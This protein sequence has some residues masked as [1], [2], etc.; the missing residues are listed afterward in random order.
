MPQGQC[1]EKLAWGAAADGGVVLEFQA[2][3][4]DF[5]IAAGSQRYDLL[6][7]RRWHQEPGGV[8]RRIDVDDFGVGPEEFFKGGKVVSPVAFKSSAPLA[9]L[10]ASAASDLEAALV[11]RCFDDDVI[12]GPH[13]RVIQHENGFF[14]GG[15]YKNV[16]GLDL[17]VDVGDG[18]AQ[19]GSAG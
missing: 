17:F 1:G 18:F 5:W 19:P 11:T 12:A 8:V 7:D 13:Q 16:A 3:L 9:D 4:N 6:E 15:N 2:A 14:G 10:G